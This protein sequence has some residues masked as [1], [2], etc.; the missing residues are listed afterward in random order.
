MRLCTLEQKL[1]CDHGGQFA[2][3]SEAAGVG[4]CSRAGVAGGV[5]GVDFDTSSAGGPTPAGTGR[6]KQING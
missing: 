5:V 1:L 2:G 4:D 6:L 3:S